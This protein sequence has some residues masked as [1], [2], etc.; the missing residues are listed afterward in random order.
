M[1]QLAPVVQAAGRFILP[2]LAFLLLVRCITSLLRNRPRL[3]T[4]AIIVNAANGD[5]IAIDHWETSIGRS[6]SCDITL[7]Y[8]TVSRFHAVISRRKSGWFLTDT[9]SRTGTYVNAQKIGETSMIYD[10][11]SIVFGN[12]VLF[13]AAPGAER[14]GGRAIQEDAAY[15]PEPADEMTD[16]ESWE[17][18]FPPVP[19]PERPETPRSRTPALVP[20]EGAAFYLVKEEYAIGR[21]PECDIVLHAPAVSRS[22]AHLTHLEEGWVISDLGSRSGTYIN[23]RQIVRDQLLYDG[24]RIMLGGV[25]LTYYDDY[26]AGKPSGFRPQ[27]DFDL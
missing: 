11:D 22:H 19:E 25:T 18:P 13:F 9:G 1:E 24:D 16:F 2:A 3:K 7:G 15:Y 27:I 12:A 6:K 21:S 4:M 8:N 26:A 14:P 23:D 5:R 17:E 10:G 20:E